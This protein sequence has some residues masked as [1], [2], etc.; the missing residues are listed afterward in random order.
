MFKIGDFSK[1]CRVPVSML[2]YYSDIGLL[3]PALVDGSTGYRYYALDQITQVNRILAFKDMGLSL[4]AIRQMLREPVSSDEIRLMLRQQEM[5]TE[6]EIAEAQSRLARIRARLDLTEHSSD[7]SEI[8]LRALD[9]MTVL[10]CRAN[11]PLPE[12]VG[13]L[14]GTVASSLGNFTVT[15]APFT[16][17]HDEEFKD[18]DLDVET[19]IPIQALEETQIGLVEGHPLNVRSLAQVNLAATLVHMGDYETLLHPYRQMAHWLETNGY[20]MAGAIREVYLQPPMPNAPPITEIQIPLTPIP[21]G[22]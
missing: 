16:I 14:L 11:V 9:P 17:F 8:V 10:S 20:G 18:A 4:D 21:S 7:A 12:D 5:N 19:A 15:G 22:G 2:R 1:F 6:Q 3:S 13:R